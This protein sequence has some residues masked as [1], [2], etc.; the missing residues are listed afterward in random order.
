MIGCFNTPQ[1]LFS[2][3]LGDFTHEA[4]T[5]PAEAL[6]QCSELTRNK[7]YHVFALGYGGLCLS[8]ADSQHRYY[9]NG[10]ATSSANCYDSIGTGI[11]SV[12]YTLGKD[13]VS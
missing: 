10:T 12:V 9:T 8:G 3:T 5:D 4:Q 11:R 6:R 7:G 1:G 2:E 13:F